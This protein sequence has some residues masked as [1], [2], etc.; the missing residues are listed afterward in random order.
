MKNLLIQAMRFIG[1]SGVGW[2]M[3]FAV[4]TVMS[5]TT[6]NPFFSNVCSSVVGATFV[7]LF[8][9][10]FVFKNHSKIPLVAKYAIYLA[11]QIA[12]IY[13]ISMLLSYINGFIWAH[14]TWKLILDFSA[15][16]AKII[17]TPITMTLNFF[18][19]KGIIE[20]L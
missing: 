5:Y 19:M 13:A 15:L 2:L 12:L 10:R 16:L 1:L 14:F 4:Y 3:D 18:V 17:V 9:T 6:N 11:Y 7:F 20:K 8:S